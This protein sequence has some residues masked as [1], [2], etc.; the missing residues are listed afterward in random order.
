MQ[1]LGRVRW[2]AVALAL[3]L[4]P[5]SA[6]VVAAAIPGSN[7]LV[8]IGLGLVPGAFVALMAFRNA[9]DVAEREGG[10]GGLAAT[11]VLIVGHAAIIGLV[12]SFT[13]VRLND[14]LAIFE[15]KPHAE[16]AEEP[17]PDAP[18][19]SDTSTTPVGATG[20]PP[21]SSGTSTTSSVAAA[22]RSADPALEV[23]GEAG[24]LQL[25]S[26]KGA[27]ARHLAFASENKLVLLRSDGRTLI[28]DV[29]SG[30]KVAEWTPSSRLQAESLH[31]GA[32]G[33]VVVARVEAPGREC[34][35]LPPALRE[36]CT[37]VANERVAAVLDPESAKLVG[38]ERIEE[39]EGFLG[40]S[41]D[42]EVLLVQGRESVRLIRKDGSI[43]REV[44]G[45]RGKTGLRAG[46]S[47]ER[48]KLVL[49]DAATVTTYDLLGEEEP[50]S[51]V[52]PAAP[53]IVSADGRWAFVLP[54][55]GRPELHS[56][57]YAMR[58]KKSSS[59]EPLPAQAVFGAELLIAFDRERSR[60]APLDGGAERTLGG[61][62]A[63][64]IASDGAF[65]LEATDGS[66][67]VY[68]AKG[69][70]RFAVPALGADADEKL[71]VSPRGLRLARLAR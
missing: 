35:D 1:F 15:V 40:A 22:L 63:A 70:R 45:Y 57:A 41:M 23:W 36:R 29:D 50:E 28:V 30:K 62:K 61:A 47:N 11:F 67:T 6:L 51:Y 8:R 34:A 64:V 24:L 46:L 18:K 38:L 32:G 60:V 13:P 56:L 68:D 2:V 19:K 55:D 3:V 54:A 39:G 12:L 65:A 44:P 71:G 33:I 16:R 25:F 49:I 9:R 10:D 14:A 69:K 48:D 43:L 66:T 7:A 20:S 31:V 17:W 37:F 21:P 59:E 5:V 4:T 58:V 42:A 26:G 27:D 52:L 53:A